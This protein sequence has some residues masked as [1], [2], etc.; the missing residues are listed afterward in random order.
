MIQQNSHLTDT[1]QKINI[2]IY[3]FKHLVLSDWSFLQNM[4]FLFKGV[5][6]LYIKYG[7]EE[8]TKTSPCPFRTHLLMLQKPDSVALVKAVDSTRVGVEVGVL[9]SDLATNGSII[10]GTSRLHAFLG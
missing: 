1:H 4:H 7:E 9:C 10:Q 3:I 6:S 5:P 8:I 2:Y